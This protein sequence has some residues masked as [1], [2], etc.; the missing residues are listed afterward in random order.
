MAQ[1]WG[2]PGFTFS[3]IDCNKNR[4]KARSGSH[5]V[6]TSLSL[7]Q[8]DDSSFF[9]VNLKETLGLSNFCLREKNRDTVFTAPIGF[10]QDTVWPKKRFTS[11]TSFTC[12]TASPKLNFCQYGQS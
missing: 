5:R 11:T 2:A 6:A 8:N 12:W 10:G 1:G 3:I 7:R 9:S 4:F